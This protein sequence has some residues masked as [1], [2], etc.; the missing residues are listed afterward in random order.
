MLKRVL[1]TILLSMTGSATGQIVSAT[2]DI[3]DGADPGA[4]TPP[5]VVVIDGFVDVQNIAGS[6]WTASGIRVV[7]SNGASLIYAD[8]DDNT[9]GTQAQLVNPGSTNNR[10]VTMIS[11]PRGRNAPG[12]FDNGAAATAGEYEPG[13][14]NPATTDPTELNAAFFASPPMGAGDV[15][16]DGYVV[17]IAISAPGFNPNIPGT[18]ILAGATPPPGYGILLASISGPD[19]GSSIPGWVNSTFNSPTPTGGSIFLWADIP[20]PGSFALVILGVLLSRRH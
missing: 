6:A 1:M 3:L 12:R 20:E 18:L 5:A 4:P 14:P 19:D 2:I 9:P 15:G 8:G 13:G 17:R 10:H 16:V 7:T 11:R